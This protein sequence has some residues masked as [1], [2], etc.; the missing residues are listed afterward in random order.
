MSI[1]V[2]ADIW[3]HSK[4]SGTPLLVLLCLGDWANDDGECWPSIS[5][6]AKK[7]RLADGRHVK[8]VIHET[9]EKELGEVVVIPGA[10]MTSTK[11]GIRSNRYRVTVH[12]PAESMTGVP[13]PPSRGKTG[14]PQP[15]SRAMTGVPQPP[16]TGVPQ[17]PRMVVDRPPEPSVDTSVVDTSFLAPAS[18]PPEKREQQ[19]DHL[20]DA[21][22]DVCG[23][24]AGQLTPSARGS[25]NKALSDLRSVDASPDE[26]HTRARRY[27]VAFKNA[28]LTPAVLSKHWASFAHEPASRDFVDT[29]TDALNSQWPHGAEPF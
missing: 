1:K 7:C 26:V 12:M 25:V 28:A 4:A 13:Q 15:P 19:Q 3:E 8:R 27:R 18:L 22:L 14:V 29:V 17:P 21:L 10:G 20:F 24:E 11:G 9:L 16:M 6:I 5:T 23:M 2:M